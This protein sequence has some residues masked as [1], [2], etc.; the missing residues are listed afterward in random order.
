LLKAGHIEESSRESQ[1]AS[2]EKQDS[3]RSCSRG[4]PGN[5]NLALFDFD[6]TITR[7]DTWTAFLRFSATPQRIAVASVL[8][9]PLIIGY[10]LGWISARRARPIVARFAFHGQKAAVVRE[11][12]QKYAREMLPRM[13]R[14]RALDRIEWHQRQGDAVVVVSASL[15]VYLACWCESIGVDAICT[16]LEEEDGRLTG[17]YLQGECCGGD[18]VRRIRERYDLAR[19]SIIYAYGDTDEDRDMLD[20]AHEKYYRWEKIADCAS[21]SSRHPR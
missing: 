18:K 12:G 7:N 6:G 15:H 17:R 3:W 4:S 16:Q 2:Y 21:L 1:G 20:I 13:V 19:Y 9:S 11:L 5:V 14:R 8:L 10:R